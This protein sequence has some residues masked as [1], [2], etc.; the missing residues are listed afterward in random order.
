[1][2]EEHRAQLQG[3]VKSISELL[4]ELEGRLTEYDSLGKE[5]PGRIW[6]QIGWAWKGGGTDFEKRLDSHISMMSLFLNWSV[7]NFELLREW[8]STHA[9]LASTMHGQI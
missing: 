8:S 6:D 3:L 1:M 5:T 7:G 9:L 4:R 2:S